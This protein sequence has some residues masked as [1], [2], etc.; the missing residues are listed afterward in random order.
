MNEPAG[1]LK[2]P[3][4]TGSP[5][6]VEKGR[7][8]FNVL[9]F[10]LPTLAA[11]GPLIPGFGPV[12][13]FRLVAL[14]AMAA[15]LAVRV[16]HPARDHV[17]GAVVL[18]LTATAL[19]SVLFLLLDQLSAPGLRELLSV[20]IGLGLLVT[21][22]RVP[23]VRSTLRALTGGWL[24]AFVVTA[25]VAWQEI[26]T[27][28]RMPNYLPGRN[29]VDLVTETAPASTLGNPNDYASMLVLGAPILLA[30]LTAFEGRV[31][32]LAILLALA[33]TPIMIF[34][35][36]SRFGLA[37]IAL[38]AA[39]M[40]ILH[41]RAGTIIA[42]PFILAGLVVAFLAESTVTTL[43]DPS[44]QSWSEF[45]IDGGSGSVRATLVRN[46]FL[47]AASTAFMGVGPGGFAA[48][49]TTVPGLGFTAGIES[50]HSL[51]TEL[52]SQYGVA[53][54]GAFIWLFVTLIRSAWI[55]SFWS[56]GWK[57]ATFNSIIAIASLTP[58]WSMMT[59]TAV[60]S[61]IFWLALTAIVWIT[62]PVQAREYSDINL[63]ASP[64]AYQP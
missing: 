29:L 14:I 33:L 47:I 49:L 40:L 6:P 26:T 44:V 48:A 52:I 10:I 24:V 59:S 28:Q 55:Q 58:V 1:A 19:S 54:L 3:E 5:A 13:G 21:F 60:S 63:N 16:K 45:F 25:C 18:L 9:V 34:R 36:E 61:S 30:G 39:I 23:L 53:V 8:F 15:S 50:P 38:V 51:I 62:Q 27:G 12:F 37:T 56:H 57:R 20:S 11:L 32:R 35:T 17:R 64:P 2:D 46:G 41:K 4:Q 31:M 42:V 7:R 43:I 22:T